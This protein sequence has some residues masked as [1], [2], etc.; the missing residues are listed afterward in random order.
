MNRPRHLCDQ[1]SAG[2]V[3]ALILFFSACHSKAPDWIERGTALVQQGRYEEAIAAFKEAIRLQPDYAQ[4]CAGLGL[5]YLQYG[6]RSAAMEQY[7]ILKALNSE[8][9]NE[10][11]DI[12]W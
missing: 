2:P 6:N 5:T 1:I 7:R 11:F 4:A 8:L 10:L 9:A 3:L 12:I